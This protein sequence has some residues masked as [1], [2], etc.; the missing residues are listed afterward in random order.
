MSFLALRKAA[1]RDAA[2]V[3]VTQYVY[4]TAYNAEYGCCLDRFLSGTEGN[5]SVSWIIMSHD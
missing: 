4:H 3:V 1:I 5:V 2:R